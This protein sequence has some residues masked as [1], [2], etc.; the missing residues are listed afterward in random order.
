ME[1]NTKKTLQI[2][3]GYTK[4]YRVLIFFTLLS[5]VLTS[6]AGTIIPLYFKA[7]FDTLAS[8]G[9]RSILL[10]SLL[11]SLAYIALFEMIRWIIQ[12]FV[13]YGN[14]VVQTSVTSKIA[15]GC[16]AY[17]HKH[18]FSYFNNNFV[19][20]LVKRFNWFS[21]AFEGVVDKIIW[22]ILPLF[23][24][25]V[26]IVGVLLN[27]KPILGFVM[28][29]WIIADLAINW[30]LIKYKLKFDLKRSE[31]ESKATGILADSITNNSN[32]KLF[33]GRERELKNY[34]SAIEDLRKL[35]RFTW[36]LDNIIEGVQ[37]LMSVVLEIV[38]MYFAA[39]LWQ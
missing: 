32:I 11:T 3:W 38:L 7:F 6:I 34:S 2:Y 24:N 10:A 17:L 21:R 36:N 20:T 14:V 9:D 27:R 28:L 33:V 23:V 39:K 12:R 31:A 18:S 22:S 4:G 15:H 1:S 19:G 29:G 8:P 30:I 26:I 5:V 13:S 16:F 25:I 35:R 37:D